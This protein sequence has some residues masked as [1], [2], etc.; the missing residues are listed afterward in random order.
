MAA[1]TGARRRI[2]DPQSGGTK[3]TDTVQRETEKRLLAYAEKKL[4]GRY[5]R[6]DI[7]FKGQFCYVDAYQEPTEPVYVPSGQTLAAV[8]ERLGNTPIHLFRLR[9]H[10]PQHGPEC[11]T[12]GFFT[13]SNEK[14]TPSVFRSGDWYGTPEEAFDIGAMYLER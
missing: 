1:R 3:I 9:Y 11:W 14:Y 12:L 5:T 2:L 6:L 13:Y 4:K 10:G 8:R 7:R